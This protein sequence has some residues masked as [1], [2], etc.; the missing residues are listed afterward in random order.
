MRKL[1]AKD[2][3]V[4]QGSKLSELEVRATSFVWTVESREVD[5]EVVSVSES[6]AFEEVALFNTT[7]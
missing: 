6:E 2:P 5:A 7:G 3:S 1:L 4:W